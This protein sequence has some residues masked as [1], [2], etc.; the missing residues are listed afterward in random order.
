MARTAAD[1]NSVGG[2]KGFFTRAYHSLETLSTQGS[3]AA[4]AG[5][6]WAAKKAGAFG[7]FFATTAMVIFMP[8]LFEIGRERQV[9]TLWIR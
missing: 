2:I 3:K 6:T 7:F 1:N 9:R 5:T 4:L 8:L